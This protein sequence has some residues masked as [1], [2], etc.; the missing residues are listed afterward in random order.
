MVDEIKR[1]LGNIK[2]MTKI[3]NLIYC[4]KIGLVVGGF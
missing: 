1:S 2:F 3:E 4:S